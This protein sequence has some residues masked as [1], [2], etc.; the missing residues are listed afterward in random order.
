MKC[1][2]LGASGFIGRHLSDGL[3]RARHDTWLPARGDPGIF[4]KPLGCV[5]YCIGLTANFRTHPYATI[6]AHICMLRR[7]LEH[8][9]YERFIYLSST[10]VYSENVSTKENVPVSVQPIRPDDLYNLTKLTG[11][12]L[13]LTVGRDCRIARLSNVVGKGIKPATFIGSIIQEAIE[14]GS[15]H[16]HTSLKSC[17]DYIWIDDA[18]DALIMLGTK[19]PPGI[20]NI[21]SGRNTTNAEIMEWAESIGVEVDVDA[22][23]STREFPIIDIER[24]ITLTDHPPRPVLHE[25]RRMTRDDLYTFLT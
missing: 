7:V 4:S 25:L 11:E 22:N 8:A 18:I 12:C 13:A 6:D 5:Y 16:L 19:G 21:A 3:A 24:L 14:T 15:I 23:A 1:T 10:R 2:V 17:K 20:I 9:N